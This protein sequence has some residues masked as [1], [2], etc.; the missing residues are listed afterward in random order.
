ML[1]EEKF[2]T[3]VKRFLQRRLKRSEYRNVV[4]GRNIPI[5]TDITIG[6][7]RLVKKVKEIGG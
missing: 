4:V 3:E 2:Q 7:K 1:S 5:I 6:K